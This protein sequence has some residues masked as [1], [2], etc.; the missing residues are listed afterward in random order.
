MEK[1]NKLCYYP[2][3]YYMLKSKCN[4]EKGH[5]GE[6][7]PRNPEDVLKVNP[8]RNITW[9]NKNGKQKKKEI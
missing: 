2:T 4:R 9:Y 5:K 7:N 1:C 3:T 6:C 8:V